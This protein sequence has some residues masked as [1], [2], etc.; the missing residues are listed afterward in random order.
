MPVGGAAMGKCE[1][2]SVYRIVEE[3]PIMAAGQLSTT[4]GASDGTA[5]RS[6]EQWLKKPE[7]PIARHM[8]AAWRCPCRG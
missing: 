8:I 3:N 5:V 4:K 1:R 7:D 2:M 6:F